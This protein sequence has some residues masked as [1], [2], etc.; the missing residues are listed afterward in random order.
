MLRRIK[1]ELQRYSNSWHVPTLAVLNNILFKILYMRYLI[2][3]CY[4]ILRDK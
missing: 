4:L 2:F 1:I 3:L